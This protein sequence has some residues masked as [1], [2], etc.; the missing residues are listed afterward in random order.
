MASRRADRT[1]L[2]IGI[3]RDGIEVLVDVRLGR[4]H[5]MRKR[6][7]PLQKI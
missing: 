1:V 5:E 7:E 3:L 6:I 4:N 2:W